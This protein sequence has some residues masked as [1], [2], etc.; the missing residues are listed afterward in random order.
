MLSDDH[1]LAICYIV[2]DSGTCSRLKVGA[3]LVKDRRIVSLGYN[4]AP[5]GMT[6]CDHSGVARVEDEFDLI[7][8]IDGPDNCSR[9]VHAEIN[10]LA[11]AAKNGVSTSGSDLYV[12]DS[13]CWECAK[14]L[15]NAGIK[16]VKYG[17]KYRIETGLKLLETAGIRTAELGEPKL[18]ALSS[19]PGYGESMYSSESADSDFEKGW[20]AHAA[21]RRRRGTGEL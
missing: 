9:S 17:R 15:I 12:T 7:G 16:E 3:V 8:I 18:R 21:A 13:P 20:S 2:A 14:L 5:A 4:G 6:H 10:T 1:F 19:P 11:F